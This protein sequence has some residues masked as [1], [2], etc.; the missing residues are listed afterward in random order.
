MKIE[1]VKIKNLRAFKAAEILLSDFTRFVGPNGA[2]KSTALLG[3]NI[4]FRSFENVATDISRLTPEDFHLKNINEPI[5][6]TVT[7]VDLSPEAKDEFKHYFRN[8]KLVITAEAHYDQKKGFAVSKQYGQRL[9]IRLFAKYFAKAEDG[10]KAPELQA[11]YEELR[12]TFSELPAAKT[13][14]AMAEAL[15]SYE[16]EHQEACELIPS[17]EN[18]YGVSQ[19]TDRLAKFVQW[20]Y[21]P[22]VKDASGEQFESKG[23]AI[24]KLLARAVSAKSKVVSEVTILREKSKA[25]YD[26]ILQEN[27]AALDAIS[28]GLQSKMS[29]WAHPDAAVRVDWR[30]DTERMVKFEDPTA[31]V[32]VKEFDFE[33]EVARFGH[34]L[35]RSYLLALLHEIVSI[36]DLGGPTL[37]LGIEE[38]ELFQHPPQIRHLNSVLTK[39]SLTGQVLITTHSPLLVIGQDFESVRH[40]NKSNDAGSRVNQATFAELNKQHKVHVGK[41]MAKPEGSMAKIHQALNPSL[42]EM[43][44][45]R[46]LV[47]VEG[48]EDIAYFSSYCAL[49]GRDE[50]IRASGI[51]LINTNKKSEMLQPLLISKSLGIVTFVVCDSDAVKP[52]KNGSLALARSDNAAIL[53]I[54]G[55]TG[56]DPLPKAHLF[57]HNLV[58]W[59]DDI[60]EAISTSEKIDWD[61]Y[62]QSANTKLGNIKN[63]KKNVVCIGNAMADAWDDGSRFDVLGKVIDAICA[64]TKM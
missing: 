38:P 39:L 45:S 62:L 20:V 37:I 25:D 17:E 27:K 29:Q 16:A 32:F 52:D 13:R 48:Q 28:A 36:E 31:Q 5:T 50:Q 2:G 35:Q 30:A 55:H 58:M 40:V 4:F 19:G 26:K 21:V 23:S 43:F 33:G 64:Q 9:G 56:E 54:L 57:L 51:H 61:A 24:S 47:F 12:S 7:F 1:S 3:L 59:R 53:S 8:G 41:D 44:F 42:S 6:V 46:R 49:S 22:A 10:T 11:L 60:G 34:G 63:A 14:P 18:F 15:R